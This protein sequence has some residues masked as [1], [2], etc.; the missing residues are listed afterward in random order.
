[1]KKIILTWHQ[2]NEVMDSQKTQVSF[3]GS[4]ANEMGANAQEKYNDALNAGLKP[5]TIQLNGKSVNNNASD[6]DETIINFDTTQNNIRD[7]VT[8]SVNN[9]VNNGIDINKLN[10]QG[11]SEDITNGVSESKCYSK[12]QIER[13]RL[14]EMRR[15]GKIM[16]KKQL[17]E[18]II[19]TSHDIIAKLKSMNMFQALECFR[20]VYGDAELQN[21]S[22]SWDMLQGIVN[23]F[24]N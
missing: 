8:K 17:R 16:T 24:Y 21:L 22:Y 7:A 20:Q 1:M 14:Y 3:N 2:L 18:N 4:N 11:N 9:A 15:N 19:G 6:K 13:A 12:K 23:V 5:N 10:V